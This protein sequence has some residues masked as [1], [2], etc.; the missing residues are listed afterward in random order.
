MNDMEVKS[1]EKEIEPQTSRHSRWTYGSFG[2][3]QLT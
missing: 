3:H 1:I 2:M